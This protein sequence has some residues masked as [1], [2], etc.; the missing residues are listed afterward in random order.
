M[1][2][3]EGEEQF[4]ASQADWHK[5]LDEIIEGLEASIAVDNCT[6]WELKDPMTDDDWEQVHAK[7]KELL[8]KRDN[9]LRL[10]VK[11]FDDL[12]D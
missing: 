1:Y 9:S 11:H 6:F 8:V 4:Q 3:G 10:I 7:E 5:I 2:I 12:W